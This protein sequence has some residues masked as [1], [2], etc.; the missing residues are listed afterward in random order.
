[1]KTSEPEP[2]VFIQPSQLPPEF[3]STTIPQVVD[4][5]K[6]EKILRYLRDPATVFRTMCAQ[7]GHQ[8]TEG[9]KVNVLEIGTRILKEYFYQAT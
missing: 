2:E 9:C 7:I 8:Q 3:D 1:M 6:C 4:R 5:I